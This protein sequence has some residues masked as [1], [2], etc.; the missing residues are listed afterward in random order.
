MGRGVSR[1]GKRP[2]A[3]VFEAPPP[4]PVAATPHCVTEPRPPPPGPPWPSAAACI[5]PVQ[6]LYVS[7]SEQW[8]NAEI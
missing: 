2:H 6:K 5:L 8:L 1:E 7:F 4:S 3:P